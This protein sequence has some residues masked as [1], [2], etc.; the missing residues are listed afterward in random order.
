MIAALSAAY[1]YFIVTLAT[2]EQK[3]TSN[4]AK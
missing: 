2:P 3:L 1:S 4:S